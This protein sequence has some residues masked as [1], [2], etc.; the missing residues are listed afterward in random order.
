VTSL[1]SKSLRNPLVWMVRFIRQIRRH[2]K[3]IDL[4]MRGCKIDPTATVHPSA[5]LELSGGTISIGARCYIDRGVILRAMGGCIEIGSDCSVNA[6]SFVSGCGGLRIG[7]HVMIGSHVS[8]Y[9]SN[10]VFNDLSLPMNQQALSLEKIEIEHDVWVGTGV[11]ILAGVRVG[12]GS[13]LAAGAVVTR[14]TEPYSING[15]VPSRQIGSRKPGESLAAG[16]G[17]ASSRSDGSPS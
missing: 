16:L 17:D 12:T 13:V 15:G 5:V 4:R 14:S 11:R 10:H 8:I 6:Y 3:L 1:F 2:L 9:A 7:N